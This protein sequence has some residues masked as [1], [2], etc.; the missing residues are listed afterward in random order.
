MSKYN[1]YTLANVNEFMHRVYAWMAG[2]LGLSGLVAWLVVNNPTILNFLFKHQLVLI[3]L[4]L[5]QL[6][7]I[8]FLS[9][10]VRTMKTGAA[11]FAFLT[12]AALNGL[13]LSSIFLVY[14]TSSIVTTFFVAAGMFLAMALYGYFTNKDLSSMGSYLFMGLVGLILASLANLFFK[15]GHLSFVISVA[16]VFIFTL[17][18]AYDVQS[19]K[20][21]AQE[22]AGT[23]M[24]L[25]GIAISGAL[26][27]YL[28]FINLFIYLLNLFG[29]R[30]N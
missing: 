11:A 19:I 2:G 17:L 28:D 15:S 27:L 6:G 1:N 29:K 8:F 24:P 18:T 20:K 13:V 22:L 5:V 9:H 23:G 4:F 14:T 12:Y 30:K 3:L 7:L 16:G 26:T 21:L 25:N 10:A